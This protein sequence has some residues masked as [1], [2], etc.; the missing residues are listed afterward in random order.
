MT[1]GDTDYNA[2][3]GSLFVVGTLAG[4]ALIYAFGRRF[5]DFMN[6]RMRNY[7]VDD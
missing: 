6:Q 1:K 4:T 7:F 5:S 3:V 2:S